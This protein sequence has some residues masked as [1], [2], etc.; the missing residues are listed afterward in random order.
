M[1]EKNGS[2]S[3]FTGP[4]T[5]YSEKILELCKDNN[6]TNK[7]NTYLY[8]TA[9]DEIRNNIQSILDRIKNERKKNVQ[10]R[11]QNQELVTEN[12]LLLNKSTQMIQGYKKNVINPFPSE[13][14]IKDQLNTFINIDLFKFF[15]NNLA[16]EYNTKGYIFFFTNIFGLA[17]K[18]IIQHFQPLNN[19]ISQTLQMTKIVEPLD[20]IL[21]KSSQTNWK[22][23]LE[24]IEN[25]ESYFTSIRE[26]QNELLI[27]EA[28]EQIRYLCKKAL[29][30]L[31][32]CYIMNPKISYE[33]EQI[34][35]TVYYDDT[36]YQPFE[37]KIPKKTEC[38][39]LTPGFYSIIDGN[40]VIVEKPRVLPE[41]YSYP[42]Y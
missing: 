4:Q 31:F 7:L 8:K 17:H 32:K 39:I 18:K 41:N 33:L 9:E 36:I 11:K 38:C 34:G 22:H 29:D 3:I 12:M 2:L 5:K 26:I 6:K 24:S 23:I 27:K 28:D 25:K 30:T 13:K 19:I 15:K 35:K 16:S 40:K 10:L 37:S 21:K 20:W 42:E 14:D 1:V